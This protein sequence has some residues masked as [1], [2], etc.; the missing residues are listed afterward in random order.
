MARYKLTITN[1]DINDI[2][3]DIEYKDIKNLVGSA[4]WC[5]EF[6][7]K[8]I[9]CEY[10]SLLETQFASDNYTINGNISNDTYELN[11]MNK[12]TLITKYNLEFVSKRNKGE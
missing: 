5:E 8:L 11:I 6:T 3:H 2:G 4:K 7:H 9:M 1:Y 12:D 10:T